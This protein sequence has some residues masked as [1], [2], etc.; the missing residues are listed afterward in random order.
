M[1]YYI[2]I[3]L[4]LIILFC[5]FFNETTKEKESFHPKITKFN[6]NIKKKSNQILNSIYNY[7]KNK[8]I[9][10]YKLLFNKYK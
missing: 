3:I 8:V 6:R 9:N 5:Y 4:L 1:K 10:I 7:N 2:L